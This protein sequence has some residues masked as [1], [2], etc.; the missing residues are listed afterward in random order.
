MS[1]A[2]GILWFACAFLACW[3]GSLIVRGGLGERIGK[4]RRRAAQSAQKKLS[5][6]LSMRLGRVIKALFNLRPKIVWRLRRG[7]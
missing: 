3:G 6:S 1:E 5:I 7:G 2:E 4:R